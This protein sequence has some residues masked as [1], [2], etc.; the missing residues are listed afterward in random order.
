M[1]KLETATVTDIETLTK[2]VNTDRKKAAERLVGAWGP[3]NNK[4]ITAVRKEFHE[5]FNKW[6]T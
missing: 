4:R 1:E 5:W 3:V 6:R 2:E